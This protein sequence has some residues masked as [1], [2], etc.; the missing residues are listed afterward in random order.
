MQ[1]SSL[2]TPFKDF[3]EKTWVL[4]GD[5]YNE[6]ESLAVCSMGLVGECGELVEKLQDYLF[7]NSEKNRL[8]L[9]KELGDCFYYL[10]KISNMADLDLKEMVERLPYC[11]QD[12]DEEQAAF[13]LLKNTALAC[14]ILKKKIRKD[15]S[16]DFQ[17]RLELAL[18]PV[19]YNY[20][21]LAY[22]LDISLE[23]ILEVNTEKVSNRFKNG[24]IKGSG[25]L[26]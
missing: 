12:R 22:L 26:R 21:E 16:F 17:H 14:E 3:V 7:S 23:E 20:F 8:L 24:L 6:T 11:F 2:I 13:D 5:S 10:V 4:P 25:D 19:V 18:K 15:P 9:I 1:N